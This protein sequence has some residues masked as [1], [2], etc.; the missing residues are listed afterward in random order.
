M[1]KNRHV[2]RMSTRSLTP[3][4][5]QHGLTMWGWLGMLI[6]IGTI[7]AVGIRLVPVYL[8]YMS[9]VDIAGNVS[10]NPSLAGKP[11]SAVKRAIG[12]SFKQNSIWDLQPDIISFQKLP[13]KSLKVIVDYEHRVHIMGNLDAV[14]KFRK[15]IN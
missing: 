13:D 8:T 15:E 6:M 4:K 11:I 2:N 3:R 10:T 5:Y 12:K 1:V 14:A 9:V 7:V